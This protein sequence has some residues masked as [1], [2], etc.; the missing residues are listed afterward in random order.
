MLI[1]S[2]RTNS[3]TSHKMN[4]YYSTFDGKANKGMTCP[5][6]RSDA[7]NVVQNNSLLYDRV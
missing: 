2:Q 3:K 7:I 5:N 4:M 1:V 6:N